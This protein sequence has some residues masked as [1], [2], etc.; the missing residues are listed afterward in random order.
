MPVSYEF[1]LIPT[2]DIKVRKGR[3]RKLLKRIEELAK[4]IERIGLLHPIVVTRDKVLVA[5]KRRHAAFKLLKLKEIPVHYLDELDPYEAKA[6]ELEENVR[7]MDLTWQENC[8]AASEYHRLREAAEVGWTRKATAEAIGVTPQ[9]VS[10][11]LQIAE[12][13]H[14]EKTHVKAAATIEA[15]YRVIKR[16]QERAVRTQAAQIDFI[17]KGL[18][19]DKVEKEPATKERESTIESEIFVADFVEWASTYSGWKFNFVH[20][21]FP[22]GVG[23]GTTNYSGSETWEKY[24]D[25]L[26]V[27]L[28]LLDTLT[29][30]KDR[31]F[32]P[33]AHLVFWFSMNHYTLTVD[34]LRKAGFEVNPFPLIW[35]KDRGLIP[36]PERGPRRVYETALHASLGDRKVIKSVPNLTYAV[37]EKLEHISTKPKSMLE[38]FFTMFVDDLTEILDPTCGSGT[39]LAAAKSLGAKRLV[40]MDVNEDY[41][42]AA[43]LLQRITKVLVT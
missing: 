20:C 17:G 37:V 33:S 1:H 11:L 12:A 2:S 24:D 38:H 39:A 34:T 23:Y 35:S 36:D 18:T 42:E 31:I 32:F 29:T 5:G 27:Y 22:Y 3:H 8:L 41:V 10:K 4:S 28:K 14:T 26:E 25:S 43:N 40:G 15:A 21:D 30:H 6:V 13:L 7:R 19:T 16:G 9:H